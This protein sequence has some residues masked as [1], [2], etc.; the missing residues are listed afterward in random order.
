M[1]L[2][3]TFTLCI[4]V[5]SASAATGRGAEAATNVVRWNPASN[6]VSGA[7]LPFNWKS[8]FAIASNTPAFE[9]Y[10]LELML[11][12]AN[13]M[14]EKWALEIP[15]GLTAENVYFSA[16]PGAEGVRGNLQTRSGRFLWSFDANVL[17][18]FHD[19]NYY[20]VRIAY[21]D[22]EAARLARIESAITKEQAARIAKQALYRLFGKTERQLGMQDLVDVRHNAV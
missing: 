15:G 13:E 12:L 14:R 18:S 21:S 4:C 7:R 19:T 20:G 5:V 3:K 6:A 17:F 22:D 8:P 1:K 10:A 9:A 11:R 16:Y 2:P